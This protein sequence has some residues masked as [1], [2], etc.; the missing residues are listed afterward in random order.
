MWPF[1]RH[2]DLDAIPSEVTAFGIW[3]VYLHEEWGHLREVLIQPLQ[4]KVFR[5]IVE[6]ID[7]ISNEQVAI[8]ILLKGVIECV[9]DFLGAFGLHSKLQV[10]ENSFQKCVTCWI[11]SLVDVGKTYNA[12]QF[13][14]EVAHANRSD[15]VGIVRVFLQRDQNV[16]TKGII[17]FGWNLFH[18]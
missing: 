14:D 16:I 3:I 2:N 7:A 17:H 13:A 5:L 18:I 6:S 9:K 11:S 1:F 4:S 8:R 10:T 12:A 15:L